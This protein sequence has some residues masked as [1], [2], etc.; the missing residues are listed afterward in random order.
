MSKYLL[1]HAFEYTLMILIFI[2]T[3]AALFIL[4]DPHLKR[5]AIFAVS[6]LYPLWGIIHHWQEKNLTKET[7]FEYLAFSGLILWI[8]LVT[9]S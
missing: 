6:A 7:I 8:L 4:D 1:K 2:T 9:I 3:L 5:T